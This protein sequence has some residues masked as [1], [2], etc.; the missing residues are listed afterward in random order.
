M[1]LQLYAT[2]DAGDRD[3]GRRGGLASPW[4]RGCHPVPRGAGVLRS[5]ARRAW[6]QPNTATIET[7]S[8]EAALTRRGGLLRGKLYISFGR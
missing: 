3:A 6:R 8:D 2:A 7:H 1:Q 4:R 5:A